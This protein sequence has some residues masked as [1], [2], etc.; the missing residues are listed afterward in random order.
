MIQGA[1][2]RESELEKLLLDER[3]RCNEHKQYYQTLKEEHGKVRDELALIYEQLKEVTS[4]NEKLKAA[5]EAN[6]RKLESKIKEQQNE[7]NAL[8]KKL[9]AYDEK[10]IQTAVFEEATAHYEAKI[11]ELHVEADK[12][13]EQYNNLHYENAILKCKFE[14]REAEHSRTIERVSLQHQNEIEQLQNRIESLEKEKILPSDTYAVE[15][16]SSKR[17]VMQLNSRMKALLAE[18]EELRAE[19][20][21]LSL[22]LNSI[23]RT[24]SKEISN[25]LANIRTLESEKLK[26]IMQKEILEKELTNSQEHRKI[27]N[28]ELS[29]SRREVLTLKNKLEECEHKCHM[30]MTNLQ[31]EMEQWKNSKE[32]EHE[33]FMDEISRLKS[34]LQNLNDNLTKERQSMIAKEQDLQQSLSALR[35]QL[36]KQS[37][38]MNQEKEKFERKIRDLE[39]ERDDLISQLKQEVAA[40]KQ[41]LNLC[42]TSKAELE[43][44]VVSLR[45]QLEASKHVGDQANEIPS[46]QGL[47]YEK[48]IRDLKERIDLL[49]SGNLQSLGD[50]FH[51]TRTKS[52]SKSDYEVMQLKLDWEQQKL[53]FQQ[54]LEEL[55]SQ[56]RE[57]RS[58]SVAEKRELEFKLKQYT[59]QINK[60][61]E[62]LELQKKENEE[63][64]HQ[65]DTLKKNIPPETHLQVQNQLTELHRKLERYRQL[66]GI[67]PSP[68]IRNIPSTS[69]SDKLLTDI[70]NI[71]Y[72]TLP[73][74]GLDGQ[75]GLLQNTKENSTEKELSKKIVRPRRKSLKM[76]EKA[77]QSKISSPIISSSSDLDLHN[78]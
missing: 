77:Q 59:K 61:R 18:C 22:Q 58:V 53:Q 62:R 32:S 47:N 46:H 14:S 69:F 26:A 20:E 33:Q 65:K 9:K 71:Q 39:A 6:V 67:D 29:T 12:V 40:L 13:R 41:R 76:R 68:S 3:K 25:Y 50:T 63:L 75:T 56:L 48:E 1:E 60:L 16:K 72:Q 8:L 51:N 15:L 30:M 17:E 54:R 37:R 43:K 45:E 4:Q 42:S 34:E 7:I 55:E 24:H 28:N 19:N 23:N 44:E 2:S 27:L 36:W 74:Q 38:E 57:S 52:A 70:K 31:I 49:S 73:Q 10:K 11:K 5:S 21:N 64:E 66:I 78:L 35:Q